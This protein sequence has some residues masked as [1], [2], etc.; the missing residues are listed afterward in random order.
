MPSTQVRLHPTTKAYL[1]L[2]KERIN[3]ARQK[4]KKKPLSFDD[5]IALAIENIT[6]EMGVKA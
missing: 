4:A 5:V 1:D 3:K 6:V 2:Q